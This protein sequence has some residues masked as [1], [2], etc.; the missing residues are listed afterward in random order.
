M[1]ELKRKSKPGFTLIELLVVVT[2]I[3]LL[4]A[5]ISPSVSKALDM[6][7]KTHVAAFISS[8]S[9]AAMQYKNDNT[10]F[11]GQ[12]MADRIGDGSGEVSGSQMLAICLLGGLELNGSTSEI[13]GTPESDYLT[14][15][16][17]KTTT[18]TLASR[19]YTVT[20]MWKGDDVRAL[21]Y[22]PSRVGNNGTIANDDAF[23]YED[24]EAYLSSSDGFPEDAGSFRTAITDSRFGGTTPKAYNSDTFILISPGINRNYFADSDGKND[25]DLM[26]FDK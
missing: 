15:K 4:V 7:K 25:D 5:I 18:D 22:Y 14:F 9:N 19:P 16:D 10:Y 20:D 21:L 8:V 1:N 6:A 17:G 26:N 23:V 13:T 12:E 3:A 2:I 24:N 11:P